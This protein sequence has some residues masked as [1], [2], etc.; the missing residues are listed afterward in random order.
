MFPVYCMY[1]S[2]RIVIMPFIYWTEKENIIWRGQIYQKPYFSGGPALPIKIL[3]CL[4]SISSFPLKVKEVINILTKLFF[5]YVDR[6]RYC[7]EKLFVSYSSFFTYYFL[8]L[9]DIIIL[10]LIVTECKT[11]KSVKVVFLF[12]LVLTRK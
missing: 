7:S 12:D 6:S 3:K 5:I 11:S 8:Q 4:G 9:S 10:V 2:G 1:F